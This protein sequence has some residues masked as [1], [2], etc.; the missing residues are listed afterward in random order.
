M[1]YCSKYGKHSDTIIQAT[2]IFGI[3]LLMILMKWYL[4]IKGNSVCGNSVPTAG[5][6]CPSHPGVVIGSSLSTTCLACVRLGF[7]ENVGIK[8]QTRPVGPLY[9]AGPATWKTRSWLGRFVGGHRAD[10]RRPRLGNATRS[11]FSSEPLAIP[12]KIDP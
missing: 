7:W 8:Q 4:K 12:T 2:K 6:S 1:V 5:S 10:V 3:P 9:P 11:S